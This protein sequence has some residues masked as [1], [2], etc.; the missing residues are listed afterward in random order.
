M[1]AE[2]RLGPLIKDA[3]L[4]YF[5]LPNKIPPASPYNVT[6][7][8]LKGESSKVSMQPQSVIF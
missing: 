7:P 6:Q 1:A 2:P 5:Q 8:E 4:K 3:K